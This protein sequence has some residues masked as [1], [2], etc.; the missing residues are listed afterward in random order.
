MLRSLLELLLYAVSYV[1]WSVH[2]W[3]VIRRM[4]RLFKKRGYKYNIVLLELEIKRRSQ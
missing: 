2:L 4:K 3:F 1:V